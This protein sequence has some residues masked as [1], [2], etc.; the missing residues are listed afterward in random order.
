MRPPFKISLAVPYAEN[1]PGGSLAA[2]DPPFVIRSGVPSSLWNTHTPSSIKVPVAPATAWP[3]PA[4][5]AKA[6][7]G[8]AAH[9][10]T[11]R[12]TAVDQHNIGNVN[13]A[14]EVPTGGAWRGTQRPTMPG[15]VANFVESAV[16]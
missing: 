2:S 16:S 13:T 9:H 8:V 6:D 10:H 4:L 14:P 5:T 7:S 11:V 15:K 3:E 1:I 12:R